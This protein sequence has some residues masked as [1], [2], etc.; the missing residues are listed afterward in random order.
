[1]R[2]LT[3]EQLADIADE[4]TTLCRLISIVLADGTTTFYYTDHDD[5]ILWS[6]SGPT[7]RWRSD[8][9]CDASAID[10]QLGTTATSLSVTVAFASDSITREG[11]ES[12]LLDGCTVQVYLVSWAHVGSG[13][14]LFYKGRGQDIAYLDDKQFTINVEPM[15]SQDFSIAE[16]YF[17]SNCRVDLG[18]DRCTVDIDSLKST[19]TVTALTNRQKFNTDLTDGDGHWNF[20]YVVFTSGDNNGVALEVAKSLHAGGEIKLQLIL[21]FELQVGD[22]GTIYPGCNK[23]IA[24]C[25]RYDNILNFRGEPFVIAPAVVSKSQA[26]TTVTNPPVVAAAPPPFAWPSASSG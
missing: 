11:V 22:T 3:S 25:K 12:G 21:P 13:A 18:D 15:L 24:S 5:D 19:F 23:T 26:V 17:S 10:I 9:G 14:M 7:F 1:M 8:I 20:G 6:G 2:A 16:E 4:T